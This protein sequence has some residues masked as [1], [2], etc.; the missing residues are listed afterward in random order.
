MKP[1]IVVTPNRLDHCDKTYLDAIRQAGGVACVVQRTTNSLKLRAALTGCHGLMLTGG[2]DVNPRWYG[3]ARH[4]SI[5]GVDDVRDKM[6]FCLLEYAVKQGLPV[7]GIC[8]GIQ[9]M[10][11]AFGGTL[12]AD[13]PNHRHTKPATLAHPIEWT[14]SGHLAGVMRGCHAV[15]ST[16]HQAVDRI[17]PGFVAT[18]RAPDGITEVMEKTDA[19]FCVG[20]QFHPERLLKTMAA[21]RRLFE[22]FVRVT[23]CQQKERAQVQ[24]KSPGS[25]SARLPVGPASAGPRGRRARSR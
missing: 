8:R 13:I 21:A 7:L 5:S 12:F 15:N 4:K 14:G 25:R 18:A 23:L 19:L 11:V 1:F 10:N 3:G 20:V 9:V 2:G 22:R 24:V 16:H 6:E 17:A